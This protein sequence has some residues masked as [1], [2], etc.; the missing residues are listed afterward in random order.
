MEKPVGTN[1]YRLAQWKRL[2]HRAE[3]QP[4]LAS[5]I[6]M[7]EAAADDPVAQ[8]IAA[9]MRGKRLP[10]IDRVEVYIIEERQPRWLAFLNA[11]A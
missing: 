8:A 4:K 6:S 5:A 2:A 10:Q 11:G 3:P 1:G 7:P 9:R